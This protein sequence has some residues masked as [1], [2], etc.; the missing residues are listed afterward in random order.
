MSNKHVCVGDFVSIWYGE[1]L[2]GGISNSGISSANIITQCDEGV[3]L[4]SRHIHCS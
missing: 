4:H 1:A 2:W 3:S